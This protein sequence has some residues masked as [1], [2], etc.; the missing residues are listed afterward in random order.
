M[1][2]YYSIDH[3]TGKDVGNIFP[4]LHCLTQQYAHLMSSWNFPSF[5]PKLE[6]ELERRAKLTDVLY[7]MPQF[8]QLDF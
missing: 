6:F 1:G 5:V 8:R 3:S 4:Q 7:P 2:N